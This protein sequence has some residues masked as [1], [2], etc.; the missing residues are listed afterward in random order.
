[1]AEKLWV[2]FA[3]AVVTYI[4][5]ML[6]LVVLANTKIPEGFIRWLRFIPVAVLAALLSPQLLLQNSTLSVSV[7]NSYLLAA[8]PCFLVAWWTKNLFITVTAGLV[9]VVFCQFLLS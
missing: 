6:P 1:M 4:P 5:R 8:V 2:I 3:M 7:H 9:A